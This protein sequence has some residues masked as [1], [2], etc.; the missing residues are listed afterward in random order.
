[1]NNLNLPV[2]RVLCAQHGMPFRPT[3]PAG[4][5]IYIHAAVQGLMQCDQWL[6]TIEGDTASIE[7]ALDKWPACCV[8]AATDPDLLVQVY[9]QVHAANPAGLWSVDLCGLCNRRRLGFVWHTGRRAVHTCLRC[10][11]INGHADRAKR[12][13]KDVEGL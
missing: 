3:W 6:T 9:E 7:A 5:P 10:V 1:M 2:E 12:V 4:Y 13:F 11:A 8:L